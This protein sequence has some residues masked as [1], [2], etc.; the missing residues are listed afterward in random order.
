MKKGDIV[1]V[2]F[3]YTD[4]SKRK[5]RPALVLMSVNLM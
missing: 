5:N 1:V 3:P 4:L 2:P